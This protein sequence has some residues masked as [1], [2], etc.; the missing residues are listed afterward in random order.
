MN[1]LAPY[2]AFSDTTRREYWGASLQPHE[3]GSQGSHLAFAVVGVGG[4]TVFLWCLAEVEPSLPKSFAFPRCP[5]PCPLVRESGLFLE[6]IL[7]VPI[8]FSALLPSSVLS[9]G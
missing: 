9:L 1:V 8:G 6:L 3:G 2:F 5:C 7:A 4:A